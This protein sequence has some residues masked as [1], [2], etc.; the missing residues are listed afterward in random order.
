[1]TIAAA[2]RV[3]AADQPYA[4][5]AST[6]PAARLVS[7]KDRFLT[8]DYACVVPMLCGLL[9]VVCCFALGKLLFSD[10]VGLLAALLLSVS[11]AFIQASQRIWADTMLSLFVALAFLFVHMYAERGKATICCCHPPHLRCPS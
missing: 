11:P 3:C 4:V 5:L 1:M 10:A 2:P 6:F 7:W 9:L 8:Q